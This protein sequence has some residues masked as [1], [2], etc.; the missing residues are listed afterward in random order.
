MHKLRCVDTHFW[1]DSYIVDLD[2][3]EKLLFLYLLTNASI[4]L[5][6][7]FE[8]SLRTIAFE[9]GIDRE[10]VAK[11]LDRFQEHGRIKHKDGWIVLIHFTKHQKYNPNMGKAAAN[12]LAV[13]PKWITE[14]LRQELET[15]P[16][17][18][19]NGSETLTEPLPNPY[20]TLKG[21]EEKGIEKEGKWPAAPFETVSEDTPLEKIEP[22]FENPAVVIFQDKMKVKVRTNFAKE[23]VSRVKNLSVWEQLLSDK[24]AWA[25][26]PLEK[27]R[28]VAKWILEA[29]EERLRTHIDKQPEKLPDITTKIVEQ[30]NARRGILPPPALAI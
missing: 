6:G 13:A 8:M 29:Y 10:M 25:D 9:T 22:T 19:P 21:S 17:W 16:E 3:S 11:M 18:F 24:I 15:L 7:C 27:R 5:S 28:S 23:I 30:D 20:R 1:S 2:P 4:G 12:E 14:T 26:E